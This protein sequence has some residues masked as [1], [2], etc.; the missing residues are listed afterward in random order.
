M[1]MVIREYREKVDLNG[2]P[3]YGL[4]PVINGEYEQSSICSFPNMGGWENEKEFA[5]YARIKHDFMGKSGNG[6][7]FSLP[8][9]YGIHSYQIISFE[10]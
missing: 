3:V 6:Y 2:S 4:Y 1:K 7:K 10:N 5:K 9:Y 8:T